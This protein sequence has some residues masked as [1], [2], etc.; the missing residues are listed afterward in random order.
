MIATFRSVGTAEAAAVLAAMRR[1]RQARVGRVRARACARDSTG[2]PLLAKD[3]FAAPPPRHTAGPPNVKPA[4]HLLQF[5]R[6]EKKSVIP[7]SAASDIPLRSS[8][9]TYRS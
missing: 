1:L 6:S 5:V 8:F 7:R 3:G 2:S 4:W 9:H